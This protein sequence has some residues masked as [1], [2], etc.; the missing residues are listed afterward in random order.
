[1]KTSNEK[2][3]NVI[4]ILEHIKE[5]IQAPDT[6]I[7]HSWFDTK[8]DIIAKL[9]NH[10]LKLKKEDFSNIE[11]LIILFAPTSDLQEISIDSGWNQLFLTISKRFDNAIKDL[12]EEFNIKP[13]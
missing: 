6:N 1:M 5:I 7:L 3:D 4:N 13:F 12:I 9:D 2:I 11:D 10:I 8:E